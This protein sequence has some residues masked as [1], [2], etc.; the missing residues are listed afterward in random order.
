MNN[1]SLSRTIAHTTPHTGLRSI[2][3][4]KEIPAGLIKEII[5]NDIEDAAVKNIKRNIEYNGIEP[6]QVVPNKGNA[7]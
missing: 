4:W 6:V 1:I 2:R 7:R 3:Y 5:A